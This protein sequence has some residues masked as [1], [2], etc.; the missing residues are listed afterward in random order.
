MES[1]EHTTTTALSGRRETLKGFLKI[2]FKTPDG[3]FPDIRAAFSSCG[4]KRC[5]TM[6]SRDLPPKSAFLCR[7]NDDLPLIGR[8]KPENLDL[9]GKSDAHV[10]YY[11]T[12]QRSCVQRH[13]LRMVFRAAS[14]R[15]T[16]MQ[17]GS[18]PRHINRFSTISP[19]S[20]DSPD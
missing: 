14:P 20:P 9:L 7:M 16:K 13:D 5:A 8:G 17:H 3:G 6:Q 11:I 1:C 10:G 2:N 4:S 18:M 15:Y 19:E 12:T